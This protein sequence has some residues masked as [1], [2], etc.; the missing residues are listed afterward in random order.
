M[1]LVGLELRFDRRDQ[2][3]LDEVPQ[4]M[5]VHV[6]H[7]RRREGKKLVC[8]L[9]ELLG[10]LGCRNPVPD[11]GLVDVEDEEPRLGVGDLA[12]RLP[13]DVQ[14]LQEGDE[15]KTGDQHR[16]HVA[17]RLQVVL[18]EALE[19]RARK[20]HAAPEPLDQGRLHAGPAFDLFRAVPSLAARE[21]LFYEAE[22]ET[23]VL[24]G[25]LDLGERVAVLAQARDEP[26]VDRRRPGPAPPVVGNHT[27]VTPAPKRRGRDAG[28][29]GGLGQR[30][31]F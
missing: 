6:D 20:P 25:L 18:V 17:E 21:E 8:Q 19:A 11:Q 10:H 2:R 24:A 7:E 28:L 5:T 1:F 29:T 12:E 16:A 22:R 30:Q 13:V 27:L 15:R 26:R 23:A 31:L 4:E 14:H 9:A 3:L